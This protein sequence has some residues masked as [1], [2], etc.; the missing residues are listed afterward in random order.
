MKRHRFLTEK[1]DRSSGLFKGA[2]WVKE[3]N[4]I[5]VLSPASLF[6]ETFKD[7]VWKWNSRGDKGSGI[8][9]QKDLLSCYRYETERHWF[10]FRD[11]LT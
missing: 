7:G 5:G 2:Y 10:E 8:I 11:N 1:V 3:T 6:L 9:S 4:I